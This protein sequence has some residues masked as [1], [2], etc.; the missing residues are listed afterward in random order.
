MLQVGYPNPGQIALPGDVLVLPWA[1]GLSPHVD[2]IGLDL[3]PDGKLHCLIGGAE[4][5]RNAILRRLRTR[6]GYL[7]HHPEYGSRLW[8]YLGHPLDA[9]ETLDVRDEV[10]VVLRQDPRV[11]GVLRLDV[12]ADVDSIGVDAQ[13]QTVYGAVDVTGVVA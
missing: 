3:D 1:Q 2:P 9:D 12:T 4:N 13:V 7:P 5:L 8:E 11:T 6:R 10:L